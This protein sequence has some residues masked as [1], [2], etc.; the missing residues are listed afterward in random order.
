MKEGQS[1]KKWLKRVFTANSVTKEGEKK[2]PNLYFYMLVMLVAGV[3]LMMGNDLFSKSENAVP[4]SVA[5]PASGETEEVEAF[6]RK[7]EKAEK[8]IADYERGFEE[9]IK[10]AIEEIAGVSDVSVVVNVDAT[11]QKVYIKNSVKNKQITEETDREGGK[12]SVEDISND[13]QLVIV[14]NGE[15]EVPV[16]Q[17]TK[18][19]KV[20]G[21]L[22]VAKGA[23]NVN[24]KKWIVE[25][26]TKSLDVP[27]HRVA[28]M[29]KK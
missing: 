15:K 22:I 27:S 11:E 13:E 24:I 18:K 28:V 23:D 7:S 12:R 8:T 6:S 9:Q 20:R 25:S 26:V 19:P 4:A 14:R 1:L 2:K 17:E 21:V 5:I 29:P 3:V 10:E 16:I